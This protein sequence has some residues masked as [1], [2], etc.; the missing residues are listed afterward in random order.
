VISVELLEAILPNSEYLINDS[1]NT[2]HFQET[3]GTTITAEIENGNYTSETIIASNLQ[4]AMNSSGNSTYSVTFNSISKRFIIQSDRTGGSGLFLLKFKGPNEIFGTTGATRSQYLSPSI[5]EIIG[6]SKTDLGNS[7][8]HTSQNDPNLSSDRSIFMNINASGHHGFDNI[9]GIKNSDF[10]KF[11]QLALTSDFGEFTF[12]INPRSS[13]RNI[14]N[15]PNSQVQ[16]IDK[17]ADFKLIFNPPISIEKLNIEFKKYN[18]DFFNFHGMEHSL[19]FRFEMFNFHYENILLDYTFPEGTE[20][21]E[22]IDV[23]AKLETI[24][25]VSDEELS[26]IESEYLETEFI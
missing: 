7:A 21:Y 4:T 2:I 16:K 25:E 17:S 23:S 19:L 26:S 10:G 18:E 1:N 8:S 13:T 12:F 5:G 22:T 11:M 15:V 3:S 6:F 20:P 24:I 14:S 9:E